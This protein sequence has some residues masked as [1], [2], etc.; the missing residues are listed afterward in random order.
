[1]LGRHR[2]GF[3]RRR[4]EQF[5]PGGGELLR[6]QIG[7]DE[8]WDDRTVA[9]D[10]GTDELVVAEDQLLVDAPGGF[11]IADNLVV[12]FNRVFLAHHR[13]VDAGDFQLG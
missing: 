7:V 11:G 5:R 6:F 2:P 12:F 10:D 9:D 4:H 8:R 13:D 1:M 3:G